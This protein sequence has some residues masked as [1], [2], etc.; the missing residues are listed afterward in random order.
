M[1]GLWGEWVEMGQTAQD[2]DV[3]H[4]SQSSLIVEVLVA[5]E[6]DTEN[7]D[8]SAP[9][10]FDG[11]QG[12]IECAEC[13]ARAEYYRGLPLRENVNVKE[14]AGEGNHQAAGAFDDK[15]VIDIR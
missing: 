8:F 3:A 10:C 1:Q 11:K 5:N 2:W 13:R 7:G 9:E 12:V 6:C 4:F 14:S 15:R